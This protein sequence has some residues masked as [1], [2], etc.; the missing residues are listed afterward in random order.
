V[1]VARAINPYLAPDDAA[2]VWQ[3]IASRKC[4]SELYEFQR[5]WVAL[6]AAVATRDAP[7][8]AEHA[9]Q[10]LASQ[11]ELDTEAR[12]Y[13]VLAAMSGHVIS[14]DKARALE[15][16]RAYKSKLR[17]PSAPAF[18]LLRCHA[19]PAGCENEFNA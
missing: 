17:S 14:G 19:S 11:G 16:W 3:H 7:R 5:R 12:Q 9:T 10:L 15:L 4:F 2:G 1:R 8:M 6:F 13:L 18:R